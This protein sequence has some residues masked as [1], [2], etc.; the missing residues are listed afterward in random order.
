M[1][2]LY[3]IPMSE[4]KIFIMLQQAY[5]WCRKYSFHVHHCVLQKKVDFL[6]LMADADIDEDVKQPT[7]G[8]KTEHP[9]AAADNHVEDKS[10]E[11]WSRKG[12]LRN[13]FLQSNFSVSLKY[14]LTAF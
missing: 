4:I 13:E 14:I 7:G 5:K 9:D 11:S 2:V 3:T 10:G 6:Q 12:G 8:P 1:C